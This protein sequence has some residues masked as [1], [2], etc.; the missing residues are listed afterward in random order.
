MN[1]PSCLSSTI[2]TKNSYVI[3]SSAG[4]AVQN[5]RRINK[6]AKSS[7]SANDDAT[8]IKF[9]CLNGKDNG[10]LTSVSVVEISQI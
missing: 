3:Y 9:G 2:I 1:S 4:P 10:E 6:I 8:A 7:N 5:S